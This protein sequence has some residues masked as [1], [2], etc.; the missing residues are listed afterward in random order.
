MYS[1]AMASCLEPAVDARPALCTRVR[2]L[3]LFIS[4]QVLELGK[5]SLENA[6]NET[7]E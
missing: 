5:K 6:F 4:V 1:R 7:N 2:P 3:D